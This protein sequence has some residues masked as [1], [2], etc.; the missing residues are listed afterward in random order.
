MSERP[1]FL[2]I[3]T[4]Q[5]RA[6]HL[7]CYGAS[8]LQTP[9]LDALAAA[10]TRYENA[11]VASPVCMPNRASLLT[12]RMPSA[13]GVR[14]NGLDLPYSAR[15]VADALGA[16]GWRTSL[17]GKPHFQC[18]TTNAAAL[19]A[20]DGIADARWPDDACYD[21]ESGPAWRA[22]PDRSLPLP[23]YGFQNVDLAVGH[24][25]EVDGNY[26]RW[27]TDQG[28][29]LERL[30]GRA[31]ALAHERCHDTLQAWRTAVPEAL[32][33]TRYIQAK[34]LER[35]D[36]HR[37]SG[38]PF[39]HWMS[40]GDPHHPFT[41]PGRWWDRYSPADVTLPVSFA[42]RR[43][44]LT[45]AVHAERRRG[46]ANEE[47]T[48]AIAVGEREV[49]AAIALTFGMIGLVDDAIGGVLAHLQR[50]GLAEN[51]VVV[52]LSDHGDLMGDHG[53]LFKGPY[54]YRSVIRTP[55]I[56]RDPDVA[57]GEVCDDFVSAIDVPASLLARAGVARFNGL[58]GR[59]FRDAA[60][61]PS[62]A[63]DSVY[64]EDEVQHP[65]PGHEG[66]ARVRT[67]LHERWRLTLYD[68]LAQ[69][70]LYD[71]H[72]DLHEL[73]NR[74]DDRACAG[75]RAEL[76]ERLLREMLAHV[77]DSPLPRYAA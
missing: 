10:G 23:Y 63:R 17:S 9:H 14:H 51:T 40:F 18:V 47:G 46:R 53:L 11:F 75:I 30:R 5:Q 34:T 41:P 72:T 16:A 29:D 8:L 26:N 56:W 15:T 52:F 6:D 3:S 1:N 31:N 22:D 21:R 12:G 37:A 33:P 57:G 43:A 25:D 48:G 45:A 61:L 39:F 24:G 59:A 13:H 66:R 32:Y 68:G 36:E 38:E 42:A 50:S 76:T 55:L 54:H 4:D 35:L 65:L 71:L 49:R 44:G 20:G 19:A 74:W 70:E 60:G 77:D 2:L 67:L 58:Q 64:I 7:G 73:D 28:A 27:V 69:G 62:A